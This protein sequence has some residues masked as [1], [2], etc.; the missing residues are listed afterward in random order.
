MFVKREGM[1]ML[2][3]NPPRG[4]IIIIYNHVMKNKGNPTMHKSFNH[5][6]S[7]QRILKS[8]IPPMYTTSS[9]SKVVIIVLCS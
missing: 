3:F 6:L 9:P 2:Y 7:V 1:K 8:E 4:D 5:F